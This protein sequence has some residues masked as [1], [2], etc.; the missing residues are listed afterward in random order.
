MPRP[1]AGRMAVVEAG[2]RATR[3]QEAVGIDNRGSVIVLMP[4]SS[5]CPDS[6][7]A[8]TLQADEPMHDGEPRHPPENDRKS[9]LLAW[10]EIDTVPL[11]CPCRWRNSDTPCARELIDW[12]PFAEWLQRAMARV[13]LGT[14][15]RFLPGHDVGTGWHAVEDPEGPGAIGRV[16]VTELANAVRG[17]V[18]SSLRLVRRTPLEHV[19]RSRGLDNYEAA[20]M[21][22]ELDTG[23]PLPTDLHVAWAT[24]FWATVSEK[25]RY[26]I[27]RDAASRNSL[28]VV[29]HTLEDQ[30]AIRSLAWLAVGRPAELEGFLL[31]LEHRCEQ[32]HI[33][34]LRR[35][36]AGE[37]R[38]YRA[39]LR[40]RR[41]RE[42][43]PMPGVASSIDDVIVRV[44]DELS[45]II[46]EQHDR[47]WSRRVDRYRARLV[48]GDHWIGRIK[49][50]ATALEAGLVRAVA[51]KYADPKLVIE[52]L[53]RRGVIRTTA[54]G[55]QRQIRVGGRGRRMSTFC[56]VLPAARA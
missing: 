5:D 55:T 16:A 13:D 2:S 41:A 34:A 14:M 35:G 53:V 27:N 45:R 18:E 4:E 33:R 26:A 52:T 9:D 43:L 47:I 54:S 12:P 37:A 40:L 17:T 30:R 49:D 24:G 44:L 46:R 31:G 10:T 56:L 25:T 36:I 29:K 6:F 38:R 3:S 1:T 23:V 7:G 39:E 32:R 8:S 11:E 50:D 51:A 19:A 48:D 22:L 28:N 15:F 42:T 20:A 21:E